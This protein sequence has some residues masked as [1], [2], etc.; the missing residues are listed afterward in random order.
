VVEKRPDFYIIHQNALPM[1]LWSITAQEV[2]GQRPPSYSHDSKYSR[3]PQ[4][5]D[6]TG[7]SG[8]TLEKSWRISRTMF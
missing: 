7:W 8:E 5:A 3:G 1:V 6:V 2:V 4:H